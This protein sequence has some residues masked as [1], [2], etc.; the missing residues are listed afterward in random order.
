MKKEGE[1]E[2]E[3]ENERQVNQGKCKFISSNANLQI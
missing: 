3:E 1:E 2:E